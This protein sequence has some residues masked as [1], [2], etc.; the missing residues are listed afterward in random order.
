MSGDRW[1]DCPLCDTSLMDSGAPFVTEVHATC[2]KCGLVFEPGPPG[3]VGEKHEVPDGWRTRAVHLEG[4]MPVSAHRCPSVAVLARLLT[5][6]PV[7]VETPNTREP[8]LSLAHFFKD[9][10]AVYYEPQTLALAAIMAGAD[11]IAVDEV[12]GHVCALISPGGTRKT[13]EEAVAQLG[14]PPLVGVAERMRHHFDPPPREVMGD[15]IPGP[16]FLCEGTRRTWRSVAICEA[17]S[18]L[19]TIEQPTGLLDELHEAFK[20]NPEPPPW[21]APDL[22]GLKPDKIERITLAKK[23]VLSPSTWA[24]ALLRA[25]ADLARHNEENGALLIEGKALGTPNRRS[26]ADAKALLFKSTFLEARHTLALWSLGPVSL[27]P[28]DRWCAGEEAEDMDEMR[29]EALLARDTANRAISMLDTICNRTGVE[30]CPEDD[31]HSDPY[32][33]GFRMGHA[34]AMAQVHW[35]TANAYAAIAGRALK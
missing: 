11:D 15:L 29:R 20:A 26:Y 12:A 22:R 35:M 30:A 18:A 28:F 5:L 7:Y 16:C 4:P 14:M 3:L 31:W 25:G 27:T 32:L 17:C 2:G 1:L 9:R 21:V 19:S 33:C 24:A 13:Y 23:I 10:H 8:S 34:G 6:G